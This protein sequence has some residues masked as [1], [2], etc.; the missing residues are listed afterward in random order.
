[1]CEIEGIVGNLDCEGKA[2]VG[3]SAVICKIVNWKFVHSF[4][5]NI[6]TLIFLLKSVANA[7]GLFAQVWKLEVHVLSGLT[8]DYSF[9]D[10]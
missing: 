9:I 10:P 4:V 6:P 2:E 3:A 8:A 7:A 1:M 5:C